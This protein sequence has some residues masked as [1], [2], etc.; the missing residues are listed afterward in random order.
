MDRKYDEEITEELL[1]LLPPKR[2]NS[3]NMGATGKTTQRNQGPMM[4]EP[5]TNL[6]P[7][8]SKPSNPSYSAK[9]AAKQLGKTSRPR[10]AVAQFRRL[11]RDW[12]TWTGR[13]GVHLHVDEFDIDKLAS[14][15]KLPDGWQCEDLF[16]V[17][18]MWQVDTPLETSHQQEL[19]K[20]YYPPAIYDEIQPPAQQHDHQPQ[21]QQQ[22]GG[23]EM[24]SAELSAAVPT[25]SVPNMG[26]AVLPEVYVFSF[27]AVVF[28]NFPNDEAE[29]HW[30]K[31]KLLTPFLSDCRGDDFTDEEIES[32][33]DDMGFRL[34]QPTPTTPDANQAN[35]AVNKFVLQR[36]IATLT[37]LEYGERLAI[38]FAIAKSSLLSIYELRVQQ[39]I[40]RNSHI[41]EELA[42]NGE[43]EMSR[44]EIAQEIGRLFLVKHGIN[45]D[46]DLID[47]PEELW[48]DDRFESTYETSL[49]Y[50]QIKPR[51]DLVN[52]RLTMLKDL[53]QV[54]AEQAENRH[55]V[56]LEWI[57]I[58]LIVAEVLL[59]MIKVYEGAE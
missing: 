56:I 54:L 30:L 43:I 8:A 16:D 11:R 41:P 48:N 13:V 53:H 55:G 26:S 5:V 33:T 45:L 7:A 23:G 3:G 6:G 24:T 35:A 1:Q 32:A 42:D 44:R 40:E 15:I 10:K 17:I 57:I 27:G 59:D 4:A 21:Q 31:D 51:L 19:W 22:Q 37:T 18:R 46:N 52:N 25:T 34:L 14:T 12:S 39:T 47:T 20:E 49:R 38:S 28:W 36:D 50:F 9:S 2:M 58:I 29:L